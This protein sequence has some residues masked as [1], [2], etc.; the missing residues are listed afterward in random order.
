MFDAVDP[1]GGGGLDPPLAMRMRHDLEA[2]RMGGIGDADEFSIREM[3]TEAAALLRQD[4]TGRGDLD[5]I[6]AGARCLAHLFGAFHGARAGIALI[7]YG[8]DIFAEARDVAMAAD[9]RQGHTGGYD[10]RSFDQPFG[11]TAAQREGGI[12]PRPRLTHRGEAGAQRDRGI[13]DADDNAPFVGID[14]FV[15]EI[16]ARIAGQ[17][18]VEVDQAGKQRLVAEIDEFGTCRSG[19]AA[20]LDRHDPAIGDGHGRRAKRGLVGIGDDARGIDER[21]L[22][23][24]GNAAQH[25]GNR[26]GGEQAFL[27]HDISPVFRLPWRGRSARARGGCIKEGPDEPALQFGF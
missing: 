1:G 15:A 4:A 16:T 3:R 26:C 12:L 14:R 22:G 20:R 13:F 18:N 8:V 6:G 10:P 21:R 25:G 9:D 5:D 2:Q 23:F 27:Q 17:M 11:G 7:E 19:G 24:G